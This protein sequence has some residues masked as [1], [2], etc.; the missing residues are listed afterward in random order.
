MYNHFYPWDNPVGYQ[1]PIFLRASHGTQ[2]F[3]IP[4]LPIY[5]D[6][7]MKTLLDNVYQSIV[8]EATA[9]DFYARLVKQVPDTLHKEFVEHAYKDEL[10]H[11]QAFSQ[12]YTH[13][14]GQQ[15]Q[16]Q[17][18][19]VQFA[20]YKEGILRAL[21]DELEAAEFYRDVQLSSNDRL[22]KDTFFFA[23]VDELEHSTQFGV[24]YNTLK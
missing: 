3:N 19:P 13:L 15:A 20:T 1:Q 2:S 18:Q 14:T 21:K 22:V 9:A 17:I 23:M 8:D 11:L 6:A 12:L 16:Y 4:Y 7:S 10:E 24:L 5:G